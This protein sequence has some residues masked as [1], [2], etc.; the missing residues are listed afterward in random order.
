MDAGRQKANEE[1]PFS[2]YTPH[3]RILVLT[4]FYERRASLHLLQKAPYYLVSRHVELTVLTI[5]WRTV[6]GTSIDHANDFS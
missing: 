5:F 6:R 2:Y 3:R 1:F 4:G